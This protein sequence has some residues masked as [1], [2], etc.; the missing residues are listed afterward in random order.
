MHELFHFQHVQ[1]INVPRHIA[2]RSMQDIN[3]SIF[4][5]PSFRSCYNAFRSPSWQLARLQYQLLCMQRV[6]F[7]VICAR[8]DI[9]SQDMSRKRIWISVR[10]GQHQR[11]EGMPES[12][13]VSL[14]FCYFCT[15]RTARYSVLSRCIAFIYLFDQSDD[16][17][18]YDD[19]RSAYLHFG[20]LSQADI[21]F[22]TAN[23]TR[24]L[25][26]SAKQESHADFL[27]AGRLP[28]SVSLFRRCSTV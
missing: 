27:D 25:M 20:Q 17:K 22:L 18:Q 12:Q 7:F 9:L 3:D 8:E 10:V 1:M 5:D 23:R 21:F 2:S 15:R 19:S 4:N 11:I 14:A 28:W 24:G 26:V 6:S 13:R 16:S